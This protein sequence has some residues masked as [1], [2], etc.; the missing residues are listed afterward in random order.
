MRIDRQSDRT[1]GAIVVLSSGIWGLY[2]LPLRVTEANGVSNAWSI[3]LFNAC[4]ILVMLPYLVFFRKP[5]FESLRE[6]ALVGTFT[7]TG[8]SFYAFGLVESEV[9]RAT[10]LFYLTPVWS[11]VIGYFW[12]GERFAPGRIAAIAIGLTGLFLLLSGLGP[13]SAPLNVGDLFA[14]MSGIAWGFGAAGLK[15][16]PN[17]PV[18]A[19]ASMQFAVATAVAAVAGV[20]FFSD[21]FP[22]SNALLNSLPVAFA[23]SV[24]LLLPSVLILFRI[25]RLL[26]PGRVGILMMSEALVAV[27]SAWILIPEEKLTAWQWAGAAAIIS[28]GLVELLWGN[29]RRPIR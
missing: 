20:A 22:T 25:S 1:L 12:L 15:K 28:A 11:T 23:P 18:A 7:G 10:M 16:W 8:M 6:I 24:L 5:Q 29:E 27:L 26:F 14:F 19:T 4:P 21:P 9:V 3:A 13:E 17:L 2:W